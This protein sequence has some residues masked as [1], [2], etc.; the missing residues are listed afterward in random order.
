VLN[1]HLFVLLKILVATLELLRNCL[2]IIDRQRIIL[3]KDA[4]KIIDVSLHEIVGRGLGLIIDL[5]MPIHEDTLG[6]GRGVGVLRP[7]HVVT[8]PRKTSKILFRDLMFGGKGG[9]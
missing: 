8:V 7:L 9:D 4:T 5:L 6:K 2:L 1:T 3:R